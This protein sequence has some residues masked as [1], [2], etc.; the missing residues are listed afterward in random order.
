[1]SKEERSY[2]PIELTSYL[3]R[4]VGGEI[5]TAVM[6]WGAPG[7]GKS[8]VVASVA[9]KHGFPLV[10]LRISQ[11][12]PQDLR[13]LP[14]PDLAKQIAKWVPP[15]F[16]PQDPESKGILF[17][18][19][20]NMAPP[21]VQGIAQQLVLDRRMGDYVVPKGWFIWAAGNRKSDQATVFEMS[22][23][24]ANRFLH[25]TVRADFPS[26]LDYMARNMFTEEIV[27]FL[28]GNQDLLHKMSTTFPPSPAWPSPR[29]WDEADKL[30]YNKMP[31]A[32]AVGEECN[33]KFVAFQQAIKPL[34][35]EEDP[36]RKILEGE[37]D[38]SQ[39]QIPESSDMKNLLIAGLGLRPNHPQEAARALAW[40]DAQGDILLKEKF[41]A[42]L[43]PTLA[44]KG[45]QGET[46]R[47]SSP[48]PTKTSPKKPTK[49]RQP[50]SNPLTLV[51]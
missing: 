48:T 26:F 8:S 19:E 17:L 25:V 30:F 33:E 23:P 7:I 13:G 15:N 12:A 5:Q 24:L 42:I 32:P 47:I 29:M 9:K 45:I 43:Q 6:I 44:A 22:A 2:S 49:T 37:L 10:D 39:F 16:F 14:V 4:I 28:L 51:A 20:I 41:L 1:M 35:E 31:I 18:D 34:F 38:A 3:D 21:V 50:R 11:L 46:L 40:V 36:I 27:G